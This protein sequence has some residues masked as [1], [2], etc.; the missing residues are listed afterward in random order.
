MN[1]FHPYL[2]IIFQDVYGSVRGGRRSD[3]LSSINAGDDD[4]EGDDELMGPMATA[5]ATYSASKRFVEEAAR[6]GKVIYNSE[7]FLSVFLM[8][9]YKF[10]YIPFFKKNL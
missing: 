9:N 10:F 8:K 5:K 2:Y 7:I 1:N 6:H 4:D 3:Y